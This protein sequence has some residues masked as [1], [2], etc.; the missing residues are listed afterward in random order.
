MLLPH[1]ATA[2]VATVTV[3]AATAAAA[4]VIATVTVPAAS[5][6]ASIGLISGHV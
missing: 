2:A 4:A 6:L 3:P 5:T 1:A